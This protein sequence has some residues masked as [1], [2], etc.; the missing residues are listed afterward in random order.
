MNPPIQC[1]RTQLLLRN[2][3]GYEIVFVGPIDITALAPTTIQILPSD[4]QRVM[5]YLQSNVAVGDLLGFRGPDVTVYPVPAI[6]NSHWFLTIQYHFTLLQE[7]VYF[8]GTA[9]GGSFIKGYTVRRK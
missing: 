8:E 3:A 7:A 2:L 1:D 5:F 6:D 4:P 9:A